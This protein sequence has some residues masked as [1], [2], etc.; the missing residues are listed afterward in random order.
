[1]TTSKDTLEYNIMPPS[2]NYIDSH[3]SPK[4]HVNI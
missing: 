3:N 2:P 1:M 4:M